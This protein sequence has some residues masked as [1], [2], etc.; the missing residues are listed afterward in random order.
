MVYFTR[1]SFW[2]EAPMFFVAAC[3]HGRAPC[4]RGARP[5]FFFARALKLSPL[6]ACEVFLHDL[7]VMV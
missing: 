2:L 5:L 4:V 6:S 1:G 3:M 7:R